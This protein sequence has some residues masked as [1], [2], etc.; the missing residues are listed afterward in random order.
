MTPTHLPYSSSAPPP[1]FPS[2]S[3]EIDRFLDRFFIVIGV[4]TTKKFDDHF[5]SFSSSIS[6]VQCEC[7]VTEE[8]VCRVL[9][10]TCAV[11]QGWWWEIQSESG[12]KSVETAAY[13]WM[14]SL[15]SGL[16][17]TPHNP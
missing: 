2:S 5:S 15:T 14:S 8:C 11:R 16:S 12:R 10:P 7:V 3:S 13:H 4:C 1:F 9:C 17:Q 6:V